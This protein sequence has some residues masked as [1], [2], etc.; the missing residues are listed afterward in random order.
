MGLGIQAV[1]TGLTGSDQT[2]QKLQRAPVSPFLAV[3]GVDTEGN[4]SAPEPVAATVAALAQ[5][6]KR[7]MSR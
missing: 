6:Q 1:I 4:E 2:A 5:R 3:A 7:E